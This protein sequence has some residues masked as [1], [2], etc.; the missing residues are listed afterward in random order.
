MT[1]SAPRFPA[2][3]LAT[4]CVPWQPDHR[5]DESLFRRFVARLLSSGFHHL[6]LF[7]TAG[8][9]YAVTDAQFLEITRAFHETTTAAGHRPMVGLIHLSLPVILQRLERAHALGVR[10]FQISLPS[11]GVL[12]DVEVDRFFHEICDRFPDCD[13]L[14]YN[15]LRTGR[16]LTGTDYARLAER[17]P[18]LVATKNSTADP[19]RLQS[20]FQDAPQLRHFITE[21]GYAQACRLGDPGFLVSIASLQPALALDYF[22]AGQHKNFPVLDDLDAELQCLVKRMIEIAAADTAHMDGAYDKM[23]CRLLEPDFPLRLLPPYQ[24]M[25]ESTFEA[26]VTMLRTEHPRWLP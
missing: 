2:S 20:L 18:N 25:S 22:H 7:G 8:E 11:W 16:L 9:G 1:A 10:Q 17:H 3:A 23:F 21:T 24:A 14:H 15:L 19:A 26:F 5:F 13:F 12:R 4:C 6:Y